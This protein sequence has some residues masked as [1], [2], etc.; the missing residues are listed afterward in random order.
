MVT[1]GFVGVLTRAIPSSRSHGEEE[2]KVGAGEPEAEVQDQE[3]GE[4]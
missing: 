1:T 4:N 2:R 3:E